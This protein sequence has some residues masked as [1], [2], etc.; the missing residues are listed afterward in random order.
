[1]GLVQSY[2]F[3]VPWWKLIVEGR[4]QWQPSMQWQ[5]S[6]NR[7]ADDVPAFAAALTKAL[8]QS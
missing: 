8:Q 2:G 1:M 5:L 6:T 7:K 3:T 4:M